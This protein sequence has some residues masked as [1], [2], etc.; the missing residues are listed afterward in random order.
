MKGVIAVIFAFSIIFF[1]GAFH[2]LLK[3]QKP[4]VYPPKQ[5]LKKKVFVL[6][7]GGGIF[8]LLGFLIVFLL[9]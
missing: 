4:G 8:L 1:F 3:Y 5:V 9:F 6:A 2:F 7:A